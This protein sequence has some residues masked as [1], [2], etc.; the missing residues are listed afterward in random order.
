MNIITKKE[1]IAPPTLYLYTAVMHLRCIT[2]PLVLSLVQELKLT[3]RYSCAQ[4]HIT[5]RYVELI[6]E[7]SSPPPPPSLPIPPSVFL[8]VTPISKILWAT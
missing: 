5:M 2:I 1:S 6:F 8:F 3:H 7:Y 4:K